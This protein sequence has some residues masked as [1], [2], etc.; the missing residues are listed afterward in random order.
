MNDYNGVKV[1][2]QYP[3]PA[4][5]PGRGDTM[6]VIKEAIERKV[7]NLGSDWRIYTHIG[8][9]SAVRW[10]KRGINEARLIYVGPNLGG[11]SGQDVQYLADVA[12][13]HLQSMPVGS[14]VRDWMIID[15]G[16]LVTGEE[17]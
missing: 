15:K 2:I 11:C 1:D 5:K 4:G 14:V 9:L 3:R 12:Y 13:D 6:Y 17:P 16:Q 7:D 8:K 10:A